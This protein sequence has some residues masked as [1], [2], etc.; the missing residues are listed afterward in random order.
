M[1]LAVSSVTPAAGWG[2]SSVLVCLLE[3]GRCSSICWNEGRCP[4]RSGDCTVS[5]VNIMQSQGWGAVPHQRLP[6]RGVGRAQIWGLTSHSILPSRC[7]GRW[8]CSEKFP[9][10]GVEMWTS[11]PSSV[12]T[13]SGV[14]LTLPLCC[15]VTQLCLILYDPM[16]YSVPGFPALHYF[17]EFAQAHVYLVDDGIKRSH[18]LSPP[19]L[20]AGNLSQHQGLFQWVVSSHLVAKVLKLQHQL[21]SEYSGLISFRVGGRWCL[22]EFQEIP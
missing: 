2:L 15:S 7:P 4:G 18:P 11:F 20:P 19:S 1:Y 21:F 12:I 22:T 5:N 14:L 8:L 3:C 10:I 9:A 16:D 6:Q 17:L 13:T